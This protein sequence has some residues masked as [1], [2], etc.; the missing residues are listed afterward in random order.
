MNFTTGSMLLLRFFTFDN[1]AEYILKVAIIL[2]VCFSSNI[3]SAQINALA[4]TQ[5]TLSSAQTVVSKAQDYVGIIDGA[6]QKVKDNNLY[7]ALVDGKEFTFPIA[8]IPPSG[9]KNYAI[10][11]NKV[12]MD[13]DGMYAE[14][15]LKVPVSSD[16]QLYFLADRVPYSRTGGFAGDLKLYLLKTDSFQVGKGYNVQFDGLEKAGEDKSCSVTFNCKGF[17]EATL[18]GAINFD[19][20]TIVTDQDT[21]GK[22]SVLY[23]VNVDKFS[24]LIIQVDQIPTFEFTNLPGFKCSVPKFTLD[25]SDLK[26]APSFTLPTW[27]KDSVTAI[28]NKNSG[29]AAADLSTSNAVDGPQWQG[30]YI[31]SITIDIPKAFKEKSPNEVVVI[32]S[33]DLIIDGNGFTAL[34]SAKGKNNTPFY[35]GTIKSWEYRIDSLRL[36]LIASSLSSAGFY[37]GIT[38]PIS[39]KETQV[40]FGLLLTKNIADSDIRYSGYVGVGTIDAQAFGVAKIRLDHTLINFNYYQ[41]QFTPTVT[42]TGNLRLTPKKKGESDGAKPTAGFGLDFAN[43]VIGSK[44]PYISIDTANGGYCQ[45]SSSGQALSNFP[46]KIT[47]AKLITEPGGQRLGLRITL[48]VQFQKSGSG[49]SAPP[50][51]TASTGTAPSSPPPAAPAAQSSETGGDGF[52]GTATFTIWTKRNA[53]TGKWEYD[54]FSL[55]KIVIKVDNDAFKLYGELTNFKNA[56]VYGTGFCGYI[57]LTIMKGKLKVEVAAIFGRTGNEAVPDINTNIN[58]AAL[59][60]ATD[61]YRYWFVD[62]GVTLPVIPVGPFVGINGFTGGLYH[63]MAMQTPTSPAPDTDV[64]C[65]TTSGL[66]YLPDDGVHLGLLAGIGLQS[67]PTDAVFNGKINLGMEFN[68]SGGLLT[69]SFFGEVTILTPPVQAPAV[70]DMKGKMQPD[71]LSGL[72]TPA[73][74]KAIKDEKPS[75]ST[76]SVRVKWFT[77]YD[78]RTE[79]FIGDF[80]VFVDVA[81]VVKGGG[82][83]NRAAHIAVLFSPQGKYVYMGTPSDPASIEV[84]DLFECQAYFCAGNVLPKPPIMPLPDEFGPAPIDYN[85][86]ETGAGLSFGAR[87]SIDGKFGGSADFLGCSV[88][89]YAELW[90]KAG[91]DILLT[92]TSNPVQCQDGPRGVNNWYATGQ[93]FIMGGINVGCKYDCT[94][95]SG[96]FTLVSASLSAYVFAQLP[97]PSYMVGSVTIEFELLDIVGGSAT[98]KVKFGDECTKPENDK[99]IVFIESITPTSGS[100]NIAVTD[101]VVV[102]FVKPIENFKFSLPDE[103]DGSKMVQYRGFVGPNNV[104]LKSNGIPVPFTFKWNSSKTNL[105]IVPSKTYAEN[106]TVEVIVKVDLQ[107]YANGQWTP[108]TKVEV[109]TSIFKTKFEPYKIEVANVEYAYPMVGMENYYKSESNNGYIKLLSVPNKP[110]RLAPNFS[111]KIVFLESGKEVASVANVTMDKTPGSDNFTYMIPNGVFQNSKSYTFQLKKIW[112]TEQTRDTGVEGDDTKTI[113][114]YAQTPEDTIILEYDFTTSKFSS[115]A[116]KIA[117]YNQP[118]IEASGLNVVHTLAPNQKDVDAGSAEGLSTL[119]TN[120]KKVLNVTYSRELVRGIGADLSQGF[121]SGQQLPDSIDYSYFSNKLRVQYD[122][123][124]ELKRLNDQNRA[125]GIVCTVQQSQANCSAGGGS[126]TFPKGSTYYYRLG[127]FLPGKDIKTSE[128]VLSFTLPND[129][130]VQ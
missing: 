3:S 39:K 95:K 123:F 117:Y 32:D 25:H 30:I 129:V 45:M 96:D 115:F 113:G 111:Y 42:I 49:D 98:F 89:P 63:H 17:K 41:K 76:G 80:D 16:K 127:Y 54:D 101:N 2:F 4:K 43:L 13:P 61:S 22:L 38:L 18:A 118:L 102:N 109:D 9:D 40:D 62:A 57:S 120:G 99:N 34:T 33:R 26:N 71:K 27:Y 105:T 11:I 14:V 8:I 50:A 52:G 108:S 75:E 28:I 67:V 107:Y 130:T 56:K 1:K 6:V 68:N 91:F 128:V 82:P 21:K 81:S 20:R 5:R 94:I 85:A 84:I 19:Q 110:M 60:D 121:L 72:S 90:L 35:D 23:Y 37:G 73:N 87:V 66:Y 126:S 53:S 86:M 10:V 112:N 78:F 51:A 31:P 55:D 103:N 46:V 44:A 92:Q 64:E 65:K 12:F 36:N 29:G 15:F 114:T 77:Q 122:V 124:S 83:D 116:Q 47:A 100:S 70:A 88:E 24:N 74:Q 58:P 79:T 97:K 48:V 106:A 93:A 119:E 104:T 125:A 7:K 69:F 59:T